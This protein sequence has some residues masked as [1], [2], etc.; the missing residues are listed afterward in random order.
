M[1]EFATKGYPK[2]T[3]N[4]FWNF[5]KTNCSSVWVVW[6][7]IQQTVVDKSTDEWTSL[8]LCLWN[9]KPFWTFVAI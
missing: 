6:S 9:G 1:K 7:G 3:L 8:G 4:D 5:W 2:T